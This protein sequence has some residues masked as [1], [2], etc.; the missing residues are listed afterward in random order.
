MDNYKNVVELLRAGEVVALPTETFY[1]LVVNPFNKDAVSKLLALKPRELGAGIPLVMSDEGQIESLI[2]KE[3]DEIYRER[4]ALQTTFW[5]GPLTLVFK[6]NQQVLAKISPEVLGPAETL[7]VRVSSSEALNQ[8]ARDTA[9]F[10]FRMLTATSANPPGYPPAKTPEQVLEYFP[11]IYCAQALDQN[12]LQND[13]PSTIVS[14]VEFPF[15]ILR[16]G[17]IPEDQIASWVS[18]S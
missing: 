8:I 10:G 12:S 14:V 3:N 15:K 5:P 9:E 17:A 11:N 13:L 4:I 7:A 16:S 1:A 6:L 18:K 2:A